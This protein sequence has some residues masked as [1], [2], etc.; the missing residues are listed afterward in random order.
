MVDSSILDLGIKP[1]TFQC[2][3]QFFDNMKT[4]IKYHDGPVLTINYYLSWLLQKEINRNKYKISISGTAA[5][6]LF[7]GYFYHHSIF[8]HEISDDEKYLKKSIANWLEHVYPIVR[9]PKLQD[10]ECT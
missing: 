6:E 2:D 7:S 3:Q 5:D 9:N 1:P 4:L 8:F 10:H